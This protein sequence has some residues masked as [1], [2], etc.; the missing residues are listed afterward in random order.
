M[1]EMKAYLKKDIN[2]LYE[3]DHLSQTALHWA[4]KRGYIEL[5][6]KILSK[7]KSTNLYDMNKRTPLY[8]A[9]INGHYKVIEVKI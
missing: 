1:D 9:V 8:E 7:G 5:V 6:E 4:A 2:Y 3:R